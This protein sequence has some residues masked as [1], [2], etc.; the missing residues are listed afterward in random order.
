MPW[1]FEVSH[2]LLAIN[3]SLNFPIYFLAGGG[4]VRR[5]S[6]QKLSHGPGL[7]LETGGTPEPAPTRD[8]SA[9]HST[10]VV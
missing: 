2:L 9:L 7:E 4:G 5:H 3:S 8:S 1:L 10:D 6:V